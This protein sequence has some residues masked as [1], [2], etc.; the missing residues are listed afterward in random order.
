MGK[1]FMWIILLGGVAAAWYAS[2]HPEAVT[3]ARIWVEA[4]IYGPKDDYSPAQFS[5]DLLD[6]M[7]FARRTAGAG[8]MQIDP[9][10][11]AWMQRDQAMINADNLDALIKIMQVHQPRYF[12][13][14]VCSARAAGLRDL[15]DQFNQFANSVKANQLHLGLLVRPRAQAG[16]EAVIA[17]GLRTP[18]FSARLLNQKTTD[19]FFNR[20]PH[21]L[22]SHACRIGTGL[23]SITLDCPKCG[24]DYN[25]LAPDSKG[26]YRYVN[27][28]LTG[29]EPPA[30]YSSSIS[31]RLTG[32][33]A[34]WNAV[35]DNCAYQRDKTEAHAT[36]DTWQL[37]HETVARGKGDCEDSSLLLADWLIC[38]GFEARVALGLYGDM[39]QHAWCVVRIDATD[40]LLESTQGHPDP[41]K[42]PFVSEVGA[43]YVPQTL[44]DRQFIYVR[45]KPKD[46][47]N[48]DYWDSAEWIKID[49]RSPGASASDLLAKAPGTGGPRPVSANRRSN[50]SDQVPMPS[51]NRLLEVGN[52]QPDWSVPV[53]PQT[54]K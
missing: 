25:A 46:R 39:G 8:L 2:G 33:Y 41:R 21:C 7:N 15:L 50:F 26:S 19:T 27:E 54:G 10:L 23:R 52:S 42:P 14:N 30:R 18:D 31:D 44:F 49:P 9:E 37:P 38:R 35:V 29:Y 11:S 6:R 48:G 17:C 4:K 40:Y 5:T 43:R 36:K 53:Q 1:F 47:F 51:F 20:C 3:N 13:I 24:R 45:A 22:D 32:L 12:H 34:I 28:F 16:Y